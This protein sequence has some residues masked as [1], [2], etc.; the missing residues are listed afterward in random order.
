MVISLLEQGKETI[1]KRGAANSPRHTAPSARFP[2]SIGSG[3]FLYV[4]MLWARR[5]LEYLKRDVS[6][7]TRIIRLAVG[8]NKTHTFDFSEDSLPLR[9]NQKHRTS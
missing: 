6:H 3:V 7:F 4:V 2:L 9:G 1:Q 5:V 8:T